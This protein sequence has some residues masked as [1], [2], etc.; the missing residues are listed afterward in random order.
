M[1]TSH[2]TT[3]HAKQILPQSD[4]VYFTDTLKILQAI[5]ERTIIVSR[6][7]I[8]VLLFRMKDLKK[9]K[10]HKTYLLLRND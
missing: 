8:D 3:C 5:F 1:V 7:W 10:K 4:I 6:T 2:I 9:K